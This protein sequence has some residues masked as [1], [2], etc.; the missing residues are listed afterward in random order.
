MLSLT[1]VP[2]HDADVAAWSGDQ[3]AATKVRQIEKADYDAMHTDYS[4]SVDAL[5]NAIV[6]SKGEFY[7]AG[8]EKFAQ[9][10]VPK[11]IAESSE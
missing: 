6:E 9:F 4:E 8:G 2:Q 5:Q 10:D 1:D 3:K 7:N 11:L